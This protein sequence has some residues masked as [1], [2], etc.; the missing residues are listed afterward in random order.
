MFQGDTDSALTNIE[1]SKEVIKSKLK[2]LKPGKSPGMDGL[3]PKLLIE[4]ADVICKP[5]ALI[6]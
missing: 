3:V 1:I 4:M 6:F 2:M 5:L